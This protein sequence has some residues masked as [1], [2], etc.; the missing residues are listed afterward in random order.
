MTRGGLWLFRLHLAVLTVLL[1][2]P[3]FCHGEAPEGP[4]QSAPRAAEDPAPDTIDDDGFLD[5]E[6]DTL[7]DEAEDAAVKVADPFEPI[8]RAVFVFND[9]FYFWFAKPVTIGYRTVVP[10]NVRIP[11]KNFF[12]NAFAP[13]RIVNNLLQGKGK[14]AGIETQ[15]FLIN[16][17]AGLLG[18]G[19]PASSF[20]QLA[21]R[22]EDLGQ[23]FAVWGIGN[24]FYMV[25]PFI[26]PTPCGTR[27]AGSWIA[28][29]VR[30]PIYTTHGKRPSP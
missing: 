12:Y 2:A 30:W 4:A 10:V 28:I 26:G 13:I 1:S 16:T 22:E 23:T 14:G 5:D 21:P 20:P 15:R 19:N 27:P 6:L 3:A 11:I 29:S 8:N 9:R 7:Y 17:T 25:L 18:F 24:G